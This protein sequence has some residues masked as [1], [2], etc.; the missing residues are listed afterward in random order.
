MPETMDSISER[1]PRARYSRGATH[2]AAS[3]RPRCFAMRTYMSMGMRK[4]SSTKMSAELQ[5]I[6]WFRYE[7]AKKK[8][9]A[10]HGTAMPTMFA[11]RGPMMS[12]ST[13][14]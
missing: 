2:G 9:D 10:I 4:F 6:S 14:L 3:R 1:V 7:P 11:S 5:F 12:L 8:S 13:R